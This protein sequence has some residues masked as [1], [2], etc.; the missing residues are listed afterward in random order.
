MAMILPER[1]QLTFIFHSRI[2][3]EN[4]FVLEANMHFMKLLEEA[5]PNTELSGVLYLLL[6]FFFLMILIGW[7]SSHGNQEH[8]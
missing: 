3:I 7:L 8:K 5:G 1:F 6:G 4:I 2:T